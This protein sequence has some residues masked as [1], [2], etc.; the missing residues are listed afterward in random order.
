STNVRVW[1]EWALCDEIGDHKKTGQ[2]VLRKMNGY[3]VV[4]AE[5]AGAGSATPEALMY[6]EIPEEEVDRLLDGHAREDMKP[7]LK[8]LRTMLPAVYPQGYLFENVAVV[9]N[10][11]LCSF[12][13]RASIHKPDVQGQAL[14]RKTGGKWHLVEQSN[15]PV[16]LK[17]YG[18]PLR[19]QKG[20]S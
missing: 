17:Q 15:H 20:L 10:Y 6:H 3:W 18:V 19:V 8:L 1:G 11:A 12:R 13:Y 2:A 14:L 5:L 4:T 7:V 9:D 16:D